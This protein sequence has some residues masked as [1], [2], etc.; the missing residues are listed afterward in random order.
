MDLID[1]PV[2]GAAKRTSPHHTEKG[3]P[4]STAAFEDVEM[5]LASDD[6]AAEGGTGEHDVQPS[7][8]PSS[9]R[10]LQEGETQE[11]E[12]I[13]GAQDS[14]PLAKFKKVRFRPW[15]EI[16]SVLTGSRAWQ[17][18]EGKKKA[19]VSKGKVRIFLSKVPPRSHADALGRA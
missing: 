2:A 19:S 11:G 1:H 7:P 5:E 14:V 8:P 15:L 16:A 9:G 18:A 3:Q 12:V 10:I 17:A 13:Y 4:S 6:V